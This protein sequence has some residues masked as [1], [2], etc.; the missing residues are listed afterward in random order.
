MPDDPVTFMLSVTGPLG[1]LVGLILKWALI[2]E[3]KRND[4]SLWQRF[5]APEVIQRD[6]LLQRYPYY[7]WRAGWRRGGVTRRCVLAAWGL[8]TIIWMGSFL[9]AIALLLI[10]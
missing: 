3:I 6:H 10:G 8:A 4:R 5:G 7:G 9:A 1:L 2:Y